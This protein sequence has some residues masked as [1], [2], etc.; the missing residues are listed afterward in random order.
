MRIR[1]QAT[2]TLRLLDTP[3]KPSN[4]R[5]AGRGVLAEMSTMPDGASVFAGEITHFW[6]DQGAG[7][8][9]VVEPITIGSRILV[10]SPRTRGRKSTD[11]TQHVESMMLEYR[12]IGE[13]KPGMAVSITFCQQ[14]RRGDHVYLL[15]IG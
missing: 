14:V 15:I 4:A 11:F 10:R 7:F 8:V 12:Q 6:P 2:S 9:R 1:E 5:V 3:S 13:A